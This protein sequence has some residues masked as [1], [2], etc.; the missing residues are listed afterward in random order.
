MD[1]A[2][3]DTTAAA[4]E[5]ADIEL[6]HPTTG[7]PLGVLI[8]V[9]GTD[10]DA[11]RQ[12]LR[13]RQNKRLRNAK[14]GGATLTAE[15]IEAEALDLLV[16]CTSG[17]TGVELDGKPVAFTREAAR[18]LYRRFRWIRE[19]VDTAIEDRANFLPPSPRS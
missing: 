8:T 9:C 1:L 10:S 15:E 4:N 2:Q 12:A 13:E 11:Y 3:L 16:R 17:W 19:Q 5:G 14:R 7:A 6:L 18:D